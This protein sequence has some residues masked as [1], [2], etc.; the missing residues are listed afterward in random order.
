MHRYREWTR[1][2]VVTGGAFADRLE[3]EL[4][5]TGVQI[6]L[7]T[8]VKQLL[9]SSHCADQPG[10]RFGRLVMV[11]PTLGRVQVH[12]DA[13]VMACGARETG[14]TERW[15]GIAAGDGLSDLTLP[16][17]VGIAGARTARMLHTTH[18]L[19]LLAERGD[20]GAL[21]SRHP[22]VLG[23]DLVAYGSAAKLS[24][25]IS[26][27]GT[28]ASAAAGIMSD[29]TQLV[30]SWR[31]WLEACLASSYFRR[32]APPPTWQTGGHDGATILAAPDGTRSVSGVRLRCANGH[33]QL[34]DEVDAVVLAGRLIP[35]SELLVEAGLSVSLPS[36]RPIAAPGEGWFVAGNIVGWVL[37]AQWCRYHGEWVGRGVAK[38]LGP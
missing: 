34:Q 6:A 35:N 30:S 20:A 14:G 15:Q 26:G 33:E 27:E 17:S 37:P 28:S 31:G 13:V 4:R 29:T 8:H 10:T 23:S 36:R 21:P 7:G 5:A 18:I 32:Y 3:A 11:S 1:L 24:I 25:A 22:L 9:P 12:A 38:S 19:D 2:R 16:G